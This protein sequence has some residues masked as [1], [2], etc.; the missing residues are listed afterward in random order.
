VDLGEF[1]LDRSTARAWSQF[2]ARLGDHLAAMQDDDIL[3]LEVDSTMSEDD[4]G[5]APY[6]QFC[7]WGDDMVRSEVSSN[8]YLDPRYALEP[9]ASDVLTELGWCAPTVSRD[10]D[11]DH[12]GSANFF[13]DVE[14]SSADRLA[15]MT[16]RALRDVFG[17][18]HPAFLSAQSSGNNG[19]PP[20]LGIPSPVVES[21]I[22]V[23]EPLAVMPESV[24]HLRSL[25]DAALTPVFG[26]GPKHDADGDIPVVAGSAL[27]FIRVL[28]DAPAV[29]IFS[30]IVR[31]ITALDAAARVVTDLNNGI[32]MIKFVL[33]DDVIIA[34]AHV[35]ALPF[36]PLQLR[37][38]LDYMSR[39]ADGV[40]D[41]LVAR[42]GGRRAFEEDATG[43]PASEEDEEEGELPAELLTLLHLDPDGD[44]T[45]EPDLAASICNYD[46]DVVLRLLKISSQEEIAWRQSYDEATMKGDRDEAAACDS[47][48]AGWAKTVETLRGALRVIVERNR[49]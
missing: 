37:G 38:V 3:I 25:V 23:D 24:E 18:A 2:Q 34:V 49:R 39:V 19:A 31:G 20:E 10:H 40:D 42:L 9:A 30:T 29:E 7:A 12:S 15:V 16:V 14:R 1:D 47:E 27:L 26:H 33:V 41:G 44:S 43:E 46:R 45:V 48:A 36:A 32:R 5:A 35:A 17:V 4:D 28:D 13:V 22:E 21:T 11:G 6:V 8:E